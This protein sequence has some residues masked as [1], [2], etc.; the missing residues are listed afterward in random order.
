MTRL[1]YRSLPA[2]LNPF[3]AAGR[4]LLNSQ[5]TS[6]A[7]VAAGITAPYPLFTQIFGTG[8]TVAQALRPY[9]QYA[10]RGYD[11]WRRRPARPLHLPLHGGEILEAVFR[12]PHHAGVLRAFESADR[13]GQLQLDADLHG[14][15]TTSGWKSRSRAYDQTHNV[16]LTYVYELPFGKGKHYLA[17]KGVASAVLGGWRVA[18]IQTVRQR[19][20][21]HARLPP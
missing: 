12:G 17:S 1:Q 21:D 4:T 9:P 16:K 13:L 3:T 5:I 19:N 2:N 11:Q 6:P 18:G 20:A 14:R 10:P 8:A 7:A 15:L